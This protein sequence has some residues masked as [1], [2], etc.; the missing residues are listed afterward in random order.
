M[1]ISY[2]P[3]L[4]VLIAVPLALNEDSFK[5]RTRVNQYK[6]SESRPKD[7]PAKYLSIPFDIAR[8]LWRSYHY[9]RG[10]V[11]STQLLLQW[12]QSADMG[13]L[14]VTRSVASLPWTWPGLLTLAPRP[15]R[16]RRPRPIIAGTASP[17]NSRVACD[18]ARHVSRLLYL[19]RNRHRQCL[20]TLQW[21]TSCQTYGNYLLVNMVQSAL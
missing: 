4:P 14:A 7:Y 17:P 13:A 21:V 11:S 3:I 10:R 1:F 16:R 6:Y 12:C 15:Y 5:S 8:S 18:F 19:R 20:Q 9:P 2:Q